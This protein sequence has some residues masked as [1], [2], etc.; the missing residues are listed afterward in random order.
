MVLLFLRKPAFHQT[1]VST[2]TAMQPCDIASL[3]SRHFGPKTFRHYQTGAEVSGQF[4]TST[5]VSF[6]HFGTGAELFRPG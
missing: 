1:I 3:V 4:G 2:I 6:A 5:E